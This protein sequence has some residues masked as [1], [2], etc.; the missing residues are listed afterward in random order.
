MNDQQ[1]KA[2][3]QNQINDLDVLIDMYD[4]VPAQAHDGLAEL[5]AARERLAAKLDHLETVAA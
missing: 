1:L 2:R 3:V 5:W 4:G